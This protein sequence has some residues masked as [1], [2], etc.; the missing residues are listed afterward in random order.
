MTDLLSNWGLFGHDDTRGLLNCI[1]PDT[2]LSATSCIRT[3]E[4]I[5]LSLP[6]T[7]PGGSA[8]NAN[9]HPPVIRPNLRGASTI[10]ALSDISLTH[11]RARDILSDEVWIIY[12][13]YS[14]QWDSFAH[15]GRKET[16]EDGSPVS[17][18]FYNGFTPE[19]GMTIPTELSEA[20]ISSDSCDLAKSTVNY[21]PLGVHNLAEKPI[22]GRAVLIDLERH[23]GPSS[24]KVGWP[25]LSKIIEEDGITISKGDVILINTGMSRILLER[26]GRISADELSSLNT[27]LDGNDIEIHRWLASS[28]AVA[29]AADNAAVEYYVAG[30]APAHGSQAVLPLHE[31]CLVRLGMPIGELWELSVLA[32]KL[33]TDRLSDLFLV[34]PSLNMP[35]ASGSPLTPVAII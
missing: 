10:N 13:Q 16:G 1:T 11:E 2:V 22:I 25:Q 27:G 23:L 17:P 30:D 19:D 29:I 12:P 24:G 32:D 4:A 8:V 14:T 9:R 3:G 7:L 26:N 6:L 15:V 18:I 34:A 35:G 21:G 31:L 20:G 28:G 5:P 33:R